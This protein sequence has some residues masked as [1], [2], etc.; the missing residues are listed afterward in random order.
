MADVAQAVYPPPMIISASRRT[1]IPALYAEWLGRRLDAGFCEVPNPFNA[2]QV[3]R[4][5]LAPADVDAIVFWTRHA[6]PLFPLLPRLVT[7]GFRFYFQYTITAYGRPLELRTPPVDVAVRTFRAL[8]ERLPPGA[9]VWRYD[10]ILV[11]PAFPLAFHVARFA[12]LARALEG[13]ARR[14]VVSVVELYRKTERRVGA[15]YVW[16]EELA[17]APEASPE[18]P[19]LLS[20]LKGI[21]DAHGMVIEACGREADYAPLGIAKTR[22]VDDRLLHELF[23]GTWPSAK[24][25]GQR[26]A[27]RCIPSKDIGMTDTCTF[28]C[29]YCYATRS[30][31]LARARY[32]AHDPRS[33]RLYEKAP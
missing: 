6:R 23:G 24:D 33:A 3:Q 22:C 9:V 12:E 1:D 13:A 10:P 29:A 8:A 18:T 2:R 7:Q 21:A 27:C 19:E 14:V 16:G 17:R 28:G 4:I 32:R 25:R 31:T 15:L 26:P 5:S 30:D 11:G 20:R